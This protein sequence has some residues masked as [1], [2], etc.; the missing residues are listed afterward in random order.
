MSWSDAVAAAHDAELADAALAEA[1]A[2]AEAIAASFGDER[3]DN[4]LR[5]GVS[6]DLESGGDDQPLFVFSMNVEIADDLDA[7]DYPLDE[8]QE[9]TSAL[10]S[11]IAGSSVDNWAWLVTAGTKASAAH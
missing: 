7:D 11:S 6:V 5:P 9:L 2:E 10:R 4:P 8:I 1:L 3:A